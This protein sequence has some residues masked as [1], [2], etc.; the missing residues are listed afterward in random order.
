MVF[1][2]R[3][4][5]SPPALFG[6]WVGGLR[7]RVGISACGPLGPSR[8]FLLCVVYVRGFAGAIAPP[9][10]LRRNELRSLLVSYLYVS[11]ACR[12]WGGMLQR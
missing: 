3:A 12:T 7:A 11:G 5:A 10:V 6:E 2:V 4:R 8:V 9:R 1:S